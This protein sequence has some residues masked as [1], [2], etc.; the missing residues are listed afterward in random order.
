[1]CGERLRWRVSD[2]T[3]LSRVTLSFDASSW[4]NW[5]GWEEGPNS[6]DSAIVVVVELRGQ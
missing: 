2:F 4:P 3:A 5:K 1:M 6:V